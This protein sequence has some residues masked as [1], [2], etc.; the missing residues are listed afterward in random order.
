M[1]VT[2][3]S[4]EHSDKGFVPPGHFAYIVDVG[5]D[6]GICFLTSEKEV[7]EEEVIAHF[8]ANDIPI[9]YPDGI[10]LERWEYADIDI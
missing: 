2:I 6:D 5:Q 9:Y 8:K 4:K 3:L 1:N 10:N 7:T